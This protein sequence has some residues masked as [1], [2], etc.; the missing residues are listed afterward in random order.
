M[1]TVL[2]RP[3][4]TW[5]KGKSNILKGGHLLLATRVLDSK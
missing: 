2:K 5:A 1:I 4:G 3:L